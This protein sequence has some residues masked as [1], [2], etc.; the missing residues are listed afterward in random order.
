MRA[1]RAGLPAALAGLVLVAS[2]ACSLLFVPGDPDNAPDAD[3][4]VDADMDADADAD[5]DADVEVDAEADADGEGAADAEGEPDAEVDP[6]ACVPAGPE[7]CSSCVG[8]TCDDNCEDEDCAGFSVTCEGDRHGGERFFVEPPVILPG[9]EVALRVLSRHAHGCVFVSCAN[10]D[11]L[12]APLWI[13]Q[14]TTVVGGVVTYD[15]TWRFNGNT[16]RPEGQ[17]VG[18][19]APG[20]WTCTFYSKI[21]TTHVGDDPCVGGDT[22]A[23]ACAVLRVLEE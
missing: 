9:T 8:E 20:S 10:G 3:A 14:G 7:V 21:F 23:H 18:L 6:F 16:G 12:P 13:G 2:A 17:P 5:A 19:S 4:D 15:W 1:A 22:L 11:M